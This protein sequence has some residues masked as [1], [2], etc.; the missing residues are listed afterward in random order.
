VESRVALLGLL[1]GLI[2]RVVVDE[3]ER[4]RRFGW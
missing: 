1:D 2:V 3:S 4:D